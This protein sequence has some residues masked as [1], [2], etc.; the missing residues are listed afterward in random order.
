[1]YGRA[2]G[3]IRGFLLLAGAAAAAAQATERWLEIEAYV[4]QDWTPSPDGLLSCS[5]EDPADWPLVEIPDVPG[6]V[7]FG[8]ALA[9]SAF[10]DAGVRL[11]RLSGRAYQAGATPLVG[12]V[13]LASD[14]PFAEVKASVAAEAGFN[15]PV[16]IDMK[17]ND[18]NEQISYDAGTDR[19]YY[20]G[21]PL[22]I[23][24]ATYDFLFGGSLDYMD[25]THF[26]M[27]SVSGVRVHVTIHDAPPVSFT[28]TPF[29][30]GFDPAPAGLDCAAN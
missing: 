2:H 18:F 5:G 13:L 25:P 10:A 1:M 22:D 23:S 8:G 3:L 29:R 28:D 17:L 12:D 14:P 24:P 21:N 30:D 11:T 27:V 15:A 26:R 6:S 4:P 9:A 20:Q 7:A 19:F 16:R